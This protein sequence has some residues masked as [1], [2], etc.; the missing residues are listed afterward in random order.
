MQVSGHCKD[1][2]YKYWGTG[3]RANNFHQSIYPLS[4]TDI[5]YPW[6]NEM[7]AIHLTQFCLVTQRQSLDFEFLCFPS[8]FLPAN[9]QLLTKGR[10][11]SHFSR[12]VKQC[13]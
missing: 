8:C 11:L 7:L 10:F 3:E 2:G 5:L 4:G 13:S 12:E 9:P 6:V 1:Q